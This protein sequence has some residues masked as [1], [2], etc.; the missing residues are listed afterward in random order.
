MNFPVFDFHCDTA[1]ALLGDDLNQAGSLRKNNGHIDL[2]RAGELGG[3]AQC[4]ACFTTDIPELLH[5][6]SPIVLFERELATIQREVDKNSDLISIAYSTE[7]IEE[8]RASGKMSAILTLEGTAG[9]DYNPELLGD[10]W[11]IGF[12]VS[13][14][15]WNE[16]NPL[17][18]S[19]VTGG[20]LTDL[21]REYVKEAQ[22]LGMRIDVSHIS[23]E[24]FWDIMEITDAP[25][26]ATHS[27]SRAVHSHSRNLTDDMFRAICE[28]GG[29][30]GYN[31]CAEFTGENP[32]LDT[33]CDHILHF[34]EL[35]PSGK[36]IALGGDL[37]GVET[38]PD[39]FEGVQSYPALARQLLSRGLTQQNI[40]DIFWN[41]AI[42]VMTTG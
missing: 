21:G 32:D 16:K 20:G 18:G 10:L 29:V 19:N 37:D 2:E 26:L 31:T 25:I 41:N 28:T 24:G 27:N 5:G 7:E 9:I 3:Y 35:D 39:G 42:R 14:L 15:G 34:M 33:A 6:I 36:H 8:N 4:F 22:R 13:S 12:R 23:D 1:L 30:A 11:A 17:T 40:M 38:M